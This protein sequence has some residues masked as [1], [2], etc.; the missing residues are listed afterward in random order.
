MPKIYA[1]GEDGLTSWLL[2]SHLGPFL[3]QLGNQSNSDTC[4]FI[5]RPSFGRKGGK[6]GAAF[7][8]F[9]AI[10]LT[11]TRNY[12]I[13]S[14][15]DQC[16]VLQS[17]PKISLHDSQIKRHEIFRWIFQNWT[18]GENWE[19]F[20]GKKE[21]KY[22]DRFNGKPLPPMGSLLSIN[23]EWV[24]NKIKSGHRVHLDNLL[25]YFHRDCNV[26]HIPPVCSEKNFKVIP[27]QYYPQTSTTEKHPDP[28]FVTAFI[29]M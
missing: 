6:T 4:T 18:Y 1:Y 5:Y 20:R 29:G 19:A 11:P 23:I 3:K 9:D 28:S 14:K 8:E 27:V 22:L 7:G 26:G 25:V 21:H 17:R 15:W 2:T 13:E 16:R 10:L 12:L 24:M